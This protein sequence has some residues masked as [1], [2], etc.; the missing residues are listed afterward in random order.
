MRAG[1]TAREQGWTL[2]HPAR[3]EAAQ[4][5]GKESLRTLDGLRRHGVGQRMNRDDERS[6]ADR[7]AVPQWGRAG[8]LHRSDP[9]AVLAAEVLD[10]RLAVRDGQ[11]RVLSGDRR[12]IERDDAFA[13][14][15]E[16][17]LALVQQKLPTVAQQPPARRFGGLSSLLAVVWLRRRTRSQTRTPF[18]CNE[19]RWPD[20][21]VTRASRRPA[22]RG[23]SR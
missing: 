7:V 20:R 19:A 15:A 9:R 6:Q 11:A 18:G 4:G 3:A 5:Q 12:R 10:C 2:R 1:H 8:Y 13:G 14:A 21:P 16:N 17:V 22:W 23:C